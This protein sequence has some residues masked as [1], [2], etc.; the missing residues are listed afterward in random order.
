MKL[1]NLWVMLSVLLGALSL[2][3]KKWLKRP[4]KLSVN[5]QHGS[6]T[7]SHLEIISSSNQDQ[8][9]ED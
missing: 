2:R 8:K 4:R 9:K 1:E 6:D 7:S 3:L 5:F